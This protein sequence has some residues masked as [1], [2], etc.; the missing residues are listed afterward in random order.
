SWSTR[1]FGGSDD[2][3]ASAKDTAAAPTA[4]TE[5]AAAVSKP[6]AKVS[7]NKIGQDKIKATVYTAYNN[8]PQGSVRLQCQAPEGSKCHD[9]S[10]PI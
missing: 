8:N 7:L 10:F 6:T 1:A 2:A 4:T 9:T 5:Q 3:T